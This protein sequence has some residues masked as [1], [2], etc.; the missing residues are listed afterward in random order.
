MN[1]WINEK[2]LPNVLKFVNT[3]PMNALKNGMLFSLPFLMVGSI[4]LILT[5]FPWDPIK[6]FFV[7]VQLAPIFNKVYNATMNL[8]AMFAVVGIAYAWAEDA[9]FPGLPSGLLGLASMLVVNPDTISNFTNASGKA[10]KGVSSVTAI[11]PDWL[12]G[13]GMITAI[14]IGMLVGGI[15]SWFVR[16]GIT[17]K[18]P[19]SVPTNVAASFTALIPAAVILTLMGA[20]YGIFDLGWHT[21]MVESIYKLIQTPLQHAS[22]GPLGVFIVAVLPV[23]FWMFGIHGT[24]IIGGIMGGLLQANGLDNAAMLKA[25]DL[26]VKSGAH[27]VTGAFMDQLITFSGTGITLGLTIY[28]LFWAKSKQ[29]KTIGK[30]EIAPALFN[31]NEPLLFGTP[32]VLN[33]LFFIPFLGVPLIS[34]ILSYILIATGILPPFNGASIPW[35]TPPI[36]SGLLVSGWK[37]AIWQAIVLVMSVVVYFPFAHKYDQIL[38]AREN[39]ETT[40]EIEKDLAEDK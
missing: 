25:G 29:L 10:V 22:D 4:F 24:V 19:E 35:T 2:V 32:I 11:L 34:G 16:K 31:I 17:I 28:L 7:N 27:I 38:L 21:T 40:E 8:S 37:M 9:G 26:S 5:N 6:D 12:G 13:K 15:Y 20:I 23:L 18:L 36:I 1:K 14:I 3:R 30:L 33:P 39:G